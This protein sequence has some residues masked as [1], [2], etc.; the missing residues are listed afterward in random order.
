MD[1]GIYSASTSDCCTCGHTESQHRGPYCCNSRGKAFGACTCQKFVLS[2]DPAGDMR[3]AIDRRMEA[4]CFYRGVKYQRDYPL[5]EELKRGDKV[6]WMTLDGTVM[7]GEVAS[8]LTPDMLI[9][10]KCVSDGSDWAFGQESIIKRQL[11]LM[12]KK[13]ICEHEEHLHT[14]DGICCVVG[15]NCR[16]PCWLPPLLWPPLPLQA[17]VPQSLHVGMRVRT[18]NADGCGT[19][20]WGT[21]AR[22]PAMPGD[23]FT[24]RWDSGASNVDITYPMGDCEHFLG[25]AVEAKRHVD[26]R[27]VA[28]PPLSPEDIAILRN[29]LGM[30]PPTPREAAKQFGAEPPPPAPVDARERRVHELE[31]QVERQRQEIEA[32]R[33]TLAGRGP[34][35]GVDAYDEDP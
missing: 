2:S 10:V 32:L 18:D 30:S 28:L 14:N 23:G 8:G 35:V 17:A 26:P 15:C 12:T 7:R 13:C 31:A 29:R 21:V 24:V 11:R 3:M 27:P 22:L 9:Y 33:K 6:R 25:L 1:K 5:V 20:A 34:E 4:D 16:L 19:A